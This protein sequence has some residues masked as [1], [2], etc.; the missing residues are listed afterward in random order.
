NT[1]GPGDW[2][3]T[4]RNDRLLGVRGA[5][6]F[7]KN[8]DT[9]TVHDRRTDGAL[10]VEHHGHRGRLLLPAGYVAQHVELAYATT[11]HRAQGSTVD[12]EHPIVTPGLT[13]EALY[14]M[15][16]RARDETTLYVVTDAALDP[17]TDHPPSAP[18]DAS[19]VLMEAIANEGAERSA[20]ETIRRTLAEAE[21]TTARRARDRYARQLGHKSVTERALT[22][23]SA[24][25]SNGW[26]AL[27]S[28]SG[29]GVQD[30]IAQS[31]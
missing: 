14:V 19:A 1:A 9:W 18:K 21:S 11:A 4:R 8:G 10:V 3:V 30:S 22:N 28:R 29:P 17:A 6:D 26:P 7:V 16:T 2:I 13:R 12:T 27:S 24:G 25:Q 5:R 23:T 31:M 15:T 20:T